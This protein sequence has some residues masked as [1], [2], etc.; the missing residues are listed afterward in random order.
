MYYVSTTLFSI[1]TLYAT[2]RIMKF[3]YK[4]FCTCCQK[5][6]NT[7][8][9]TRGVINCNIFNIC[10]ETTEK[11]DKLSISS[12]EMFDRS[13][14]PAIITNSPPTSTRRLRTSAKVRENSC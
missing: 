7:E 2:S 8:N 13:K 12:I 9:D 10:K 6:P 4:I 3:I 5:Q 1:I 14:H 11:T